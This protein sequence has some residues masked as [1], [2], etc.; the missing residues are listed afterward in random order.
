MLPETIAGQV[1]LING[2]TG[3]IAACP[4]WSLEWTK[5]GWV[6]GQYSPYKLKDRIASELRYDNYIPGQ[7]LLWPR[8]IIEQLG[9]WQ[10]NLSG[11][12]DGDLRMR[13]LLAG[14]KILDTSIGGFVWRRYSTSTLSHQ[15]SEYHLKSRIRILDKIE[16]G[17]IR[18]GQLDKYRFDLACAYHR[19]ATSIMPL[20][21]TLGDIAWE[22]AMKLGGLQS[23]Q[24]SLKHRLLC[25]SIG[26]KRK[27]RLVKWLSNTVFSVVLSRS[28][29]RP[30]LIEFSAQSEKNYTSTEQILNHTKET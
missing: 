24:G 25:Y 26:L 6:K 10:E 17:L 5:N 19:A 2:L 4:W 12:D 3:T 29:H 11:N 28:R 9:G 7:A 30:T 1:E 18:T 8:E 20:N 16:A 21:E 22:H 14:H 15:K 13:A 23:I 27:E